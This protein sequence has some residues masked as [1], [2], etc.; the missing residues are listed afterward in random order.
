M[1]VDANQAEDVKEKS[2]RVK[3]EEVEERDL[4][5]SS[6]HTNCKSERSLY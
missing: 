2:C 3:N 4:P 5:P 1:I 6:I